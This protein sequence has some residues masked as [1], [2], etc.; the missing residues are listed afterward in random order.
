MLDSTFIRSIVYLHNAF[1]PFLS[2]IFNQL[3]PRFNSSEAYEY[4]KEKLH[5]VTESHVFRP[6]HEY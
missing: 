1:E 2:F 6:N 4:F 3:S 5:H